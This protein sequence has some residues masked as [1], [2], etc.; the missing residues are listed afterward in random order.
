MKTFLEMTAEERRINALS[1]T[2]LY[3][4]ISHKLPGHEFAQEVVDDRRRLEK[5][6]D[7]D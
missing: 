2:E 7:G 6:N 1:Y 4:I 3:Y 5:Q